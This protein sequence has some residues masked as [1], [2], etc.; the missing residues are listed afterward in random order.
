MDFFLTVYHPGS[1][2]VFLPL[3]FP[4]PFVFLLSFATLHSQ[5]CNTSSAPLAMTPSSFPPP[6]HLLH[7]PL[8]GNFH[9]HFSIALFWPQDIQ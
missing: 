1:I 6:R 3:L 4:L 7:S 2:S 8:H 9:P 5:H